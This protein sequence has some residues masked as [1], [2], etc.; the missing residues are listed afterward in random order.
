MEKTP[1]NTFKISKPDGQRFIESGNVNC[2]EGDKAIAS[3][4]AKL[5]LDAGAYRVDI[6]RDV[7]VFT[8]DP[9][10][11]IE[12]KL[13]QNFKRITQE[14]LQSGKPITSYTLAAPENTVD[15]DATAIKNVQQ[16]IQNSTE[17]KI[18]FLVSQPNE[19]TLAKIQ[20]IMVNSNEN[21]PI[22][23]QIRNHLENPEGQT[24][25]AKV[26]DL[27]YAS[28]IASMMGKFSQYSMQEITARNALIHMRAIAANVDDGQNQTIRNI[29]ET[30]AAYAAQAIIEGEVVQA[31]FE[32]H[33]AQII[34]K[35]LKDGLLTVELLG[36][37]ESCK[38]TQVSM[39]NNAK[40]AI[41]VGLGQPYVKEVINA[42]KKN[43]QVEEVNNQTA[44]AAAGV[45]GVDVPKKPSK[46]DRF[47]AMDN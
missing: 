11:S 20:Q 14:Y 24:T 1:G 32:A 44:A 23:T 40:N 35:S 13:A 7:N 16:I 26:Q 30:T 27:M 9:S 8:R 41:N 37:C 28:P 31:A 43:P 6:N 36:S 19:M 34:F 17:A 12:S 42:A 22:L 47:K 15:L 39:E 10:T 4:L 21:N 25:I 3:D 33:A 38:L 18:L 45:P 2:K 5:L 46:L 29:H